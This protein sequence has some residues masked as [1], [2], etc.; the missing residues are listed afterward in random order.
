MVNKLEWLW[1][2]LKRLFRK[3]RPGGARPHMWPTREE[4]NLLP[5][6]EGLERNGIALIT[7]PESA[8]RAFD[9]LASAEAVGFDTESK[10]TFKK[11]EVSHGPHVAQFST[12]KRAYVF[13]LH[14]P[15]CRRVVGELLA[16][17]GLKKVGFGL[18]HDIRDARTKLHVTPHNVLD[19]ESLFR[20]KGHGRGVGAKVGIALVFKRRLRKSK[21]ISSSNWGSRH[22]TDQQILYAANDAYAAIRAYNA[23]VHH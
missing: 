21:R 7:G 18:S 4:I 14:E 1:R 16:L 9:E 8:R 19:L 20:E 10:P 13:L 5:W 6:F 23:L 12:M 2:W 3:R 15:E 22:L 11:G 17:P